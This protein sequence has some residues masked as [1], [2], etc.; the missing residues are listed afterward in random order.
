MKKQL[1]FCLLLIPFSS[2]VASDYNAEAINRIIGEKGARW[3]ATENRITAMAAEER[4]MLCG[5]IMLPDY[6][7]NPEILSFEA[8][9]DIPSHLD[10]R[11]NNGNWV[12][13]VRDQ[14]QCGSCVAFSELG[15]IESWWKIRNANTDTVIDLSEQI[16][17]S[18]S[19]AVTCAH[20]G[21]MSSVLE[22]VKLNGVPLEECMSYQALDGI[23]CSNACDDWQAQSVTIP[24]WGWVSYEKD[25]VANI[26]SALYRHPVS[27]SFTVYS[28]F[29]G[30]HSGVYEHVYG[31]AEGGHAIL[32]V[33][34]DD[35]EQ[36]WICKNSWGVDWGEEGYFR[37]KWGD[38][39]MGDYAPFIYDGMTSRVSVQLAPDIFEFDMTVGDSSIHELEVTNIGPD[40]LEYAA[41]DYMYGNG[42]PAWME[43]M[44]GG[45]VLAPGETMPIRF[46]VKT[47][48]LDP[49]TY[50][51]RLGVRSNDSY[52]PLKELICRLNLVPPDHDLKVSQIL[53][54]NDY[55]RIFSYMQF[56]STI[57]NE[58]LSSETN[59][60]V[61][62]TIRMGDQI[63]FS[64]TV[65]IDAIAQF[66]VI[67]I[68]FDSLYI[69]QSG[70]LDIHVEL[71]NLDN[72][73][74]G[75]NDY[76][77]QT[78]EVK[79]LVDS[80]ENECDLWLCE[81]GWGVSNLLN[82]HS[83]SHSA[84]VNSGAFPYL[85]DMSGSMTFVPGF[86]LH[87]VKSAVIKY[88]TRYAT[89]KDKDVC[90]IEV[91]GD[92]EK[93]DLMDTIS[94]INLAWTQREL[95]ITDYIKPEYPRVW[96]RFRFI[97]DSD[98]NNV[99]VLIDDIEI[100]PLESTHVSDFSQPSAQPTDLA[101]FQNYPNPFNPVTTISYRLP[102]ESDVDLS[103]YNLN[104]QRI[105]TLMNG[106]QT[107]GH[108]TITWNGRD[109]AGSLMSSGIYLYRL[110]AGN[111]I[112]TRKLTLM[113]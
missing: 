30:Y 54:P 62:G 110:N 52:L 55:V 12:T 101:L 89:E 36:S 31:N 65:R 20:G 21:Y 72:D 84:H 99:G 74:N 14:G 112:Q 64:D 108:Y 76:L 32:I 100:Y 33:G 111:E 106:R 81:G 56:T 85:N 50:R 90:Y 68:K 39:N 2:G 71:L 6:S 66:G 35:E 15:Q 86:E 26:K 91:S 23:P 37:I 28:D 45:G 9:K 49:G 83:G 4:K 61:L 7:V 88:Y 79:H 17:L 16:I 97:S 109:D 22:W 73:H 113:K 43:I 10:W 47:R 103:I 1:I 105:L 67:S 25:I 69:T 29:Y 53:L 75:Y 3:T 77:N 13:P 96:V 80:F 59:V 44:D 27:A 70:V 82:G 60:D 94:G 95:N 41:M 38:S 87:A 104:G 48:E 98:I 58:G 24:G 102:S 93:W 78:V 51:A 34:W 11:D 5:E 19:N 63:V 92:N 107:A 8:V 46:K 40:N 57:S 18:C 42:V